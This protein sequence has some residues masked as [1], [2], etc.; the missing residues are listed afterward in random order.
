M[1]SWLE[2]LENAA[3]SIIGAVGSGAASKIESELAGKPPKSD[4]PETQIETT[5]QRPLDGPGSKSQPAPTAMTAFNDAWS[6]YKW[7]IGGALA[8]TAFMAWRGSR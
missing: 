3:G 6:Q 8:F 2:E 5:I 4:Q 7:V 1:A